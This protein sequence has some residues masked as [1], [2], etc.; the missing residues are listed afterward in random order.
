[1]LTIACGLCKMSVQLQRSRSRGVLEKL[2]SPVLVPMRCEL[3]GNRQY[4]FSWVK[5]IPKRP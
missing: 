5:P 1:M 2:L 3:C 4:K